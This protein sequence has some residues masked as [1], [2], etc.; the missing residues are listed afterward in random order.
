MVNRS[1]A[2]CRASSDRKCSRPTEGRPH[3]GDKHLG[4]ARRPV[5]CSCGCMYMPLP[6]PH[7]RRSP[8][9]TCSMLTAVRPGGVRRLAD[10]CAKKRGALRSASPCK[11]N[12]SRPWA[13]RSKRSSALS[14]NTRRLRTPLVRLSNQTGASFLLRILFIF[15][16]S[17]NVSKLLPGLRIGTI[18]QRSLFTRTVVY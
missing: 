9:S 17:Y 5:A 12:K 13:P 11:R 10:R 7:G 18:G 6:M 4:R 15:D 14:S 2:R 1:M 3:L 8:V 16:D